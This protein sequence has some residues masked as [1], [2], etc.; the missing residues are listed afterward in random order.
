[1][2]PIVPPEQRFA[3]NLQSRR[4]ATSLFTEKVFDFLAN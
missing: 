3:L 1:M 4:S 2:S